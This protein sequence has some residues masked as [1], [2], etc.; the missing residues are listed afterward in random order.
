MSVFRDKKYE[1]LDWISAAT[2]PIESPLNE[3]LAILPDEVDIN[4]DTYILSLGDSWNMDLAVSNVVRLL[5][6][7]IKSSSIENAELVSF[8][9]WQNQST[10]FDCFELETEGSP[11]LDFVSKM[12]DGGKLR[13]MKRKFTLDE[14]VLEDTLGDRGIGCVQSMALYPDAIGRLNDIMGILGKCEEGL[15]TKSI[16]KKRYHLA[17][18]FASIIK[19]NEWNIKD[20]ALADKVGAWI[21]AYVEKGDISAFANLGRLKVMTHSGNPIYSMEEIA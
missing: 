19:S 11:V 20:A 15:K 8:V 9:S 18:R 3:I 1:S 17:R 16:R 10:L 13:L 6:N 7:N 12:I 2:E 21:A 14:Q 5:L 4:F